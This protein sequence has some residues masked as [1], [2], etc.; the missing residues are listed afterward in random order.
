[1]PR[2]I[3]T[4][5][6]RVARNLVWT[7]TG[8][9]KNLNVSKKTVQMI[10]KNNLKAK[11]LAQK[12]KILLTDCIKVAR[13]DHCQKILSKIKKNMPII[14]FTDEKYFT[15]NPI[16]HSCTSRY[17]AKGRAKDI[18]DH[19]KCV[20]N[21][22]YLAKIMMLG[23]DA[24]KGLKMDPVYLPIGLRM[25]AKDYLELVLNAHVLPWIQDNFND[26]KTMVLMQDGAPC[27]NANL[28]QNWLWTHIKFWPKDVW[29]SSSPDL[30][31]L[32]FSL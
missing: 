31:P 22:K 6:S 24:S 4:I 25:G 11:S 29:P 2:L 7:M 26:D 30:N 19:I 1:M 28:I 10:V 13:F 9:A 27:H 14:Q 3:N 17:I 18:P 15:V 23:L 32:D 8:M 21:S 5:K 12:Q 16:T 20:Q